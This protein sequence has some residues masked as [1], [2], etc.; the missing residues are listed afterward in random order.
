MNTTWMRRYLPA[1]GLGLLVGVAIGVHLWRCN[2][3]HHKGGNPTTRIVERFGRDLK[4]APEQKAKLAVILDRTHNRMLALKTKS[5]AEFQALQKETAT[6]IEKILTKEQQVLFAAM[7]KK[8]LVRMQK[9][10]HGPEGSCPPPPDK[11]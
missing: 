10:G 4:L 1:F 5:S 2:P 7:E 9:G 6:A 3:F 11:P 8:H